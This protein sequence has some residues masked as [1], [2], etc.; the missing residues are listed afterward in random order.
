MKSA[1]V[2]LLLIVC[3][4]SSGAQQA[5]TDSSFAA[6]ISAS[7]PIYWGQILKETSDTVFFRG[8]DGVVMQ[9]PRTA[10]DEILYGKKKVS[11]FW[12]VGVVLGLPELIDLVVACHW[13]WIGL[14]MSGSYWGSDS[15]GLQINLPFNIYRGLSTSHD[16][17]IV[18][19]DGSPIDVSDGGQRKSIP[20]RGWG[21][22]YD[23]NLSGFCLELGLFKFSS[24][25]DFGL[26]GQIGYV[27]QFR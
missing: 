25:Q 6:I 12:E 15:Y 21:G 18:Y 10:I 27:Y 14:R 3:S 20:F 19:T 22:A 2:I 1:A 5:R 8:D 17:S 26:L 24:S 13:K 9:L 4:G 23:L 11:S 16:I 7:G